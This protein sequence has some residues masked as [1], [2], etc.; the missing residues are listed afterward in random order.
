MTALFWLGLGICIAVST[1]IGVAAGLLYIGA[2]SVVL[3]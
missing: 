1:S 3:K 2:L